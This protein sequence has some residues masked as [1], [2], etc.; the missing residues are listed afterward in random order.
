M[1]L[2]K[3]LSYLIILTL[4]L[5]SLN[6]TVSNI[7]DW[8][9]FQASYGTE[10]QPNKYQ[11]G[12]FG[13]IAFGLKDETHLQSCLYHPKLDC[14]NDGTKWVL[15]VQAAQLIFDKNKGVGSI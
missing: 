10:F 12:F 13:S 6:L 11:V 9:G 3:Q 8:W 2:G 7:K 4:H 15:Q 5:K 14:S 1:Q